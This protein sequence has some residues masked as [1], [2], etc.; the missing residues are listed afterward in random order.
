MKKLV[1]SRQLLYNLVDIVWQDVN[2]DKSVPSTKHARALIKKAIE[3]TRQE[4]YSQIR[5]LKPAC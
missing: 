5:I 1:L 4:K 2:E 3:K